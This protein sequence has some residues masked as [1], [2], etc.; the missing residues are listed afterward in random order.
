MNPVHR[1]LRYAKA[2]F[3]LNDLHRRTEVLTGDSAKLIRT[4]FDYAEGFFAP[5]QVEEELVRLVDDVRKVAPK[6]VLEIGTSMGG[7]LY[8]WSRLS[9]ND[10]NII[11]V[12][13]PHGKFGGGYSPLR[14]PLYR[15]FRRAAQTLHLLRADSHQPATFQQVK[16]LLNNKPVDF[17]FIDGDHTYEGVKQDWVTYSKLVRPGG[18]VAFHDIALNYEDTQ[19]KRF[20]D[21]LKPTVTHREYAYHPRGFYGIGV[22]EI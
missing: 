14:T 18:L 22:V 12:D 10:A 13:L 2:Y 16:A 9:A 3:G 7:T 19:V 20:W 8:L 21:E 4:T 17:L 6:T 1:L 5:I 11:S 15:S